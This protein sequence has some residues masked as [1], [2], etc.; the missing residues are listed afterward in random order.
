MPIYEYTCL[1]CGTAFEKLVRNAE[2]TR[3]IKCPVCGEE[4]VEEKVSSCATFVKGGS[5]APGGNC[6]PT[7]G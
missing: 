6:A 2:S 4:E 5:S 3:E 1:G 7:G